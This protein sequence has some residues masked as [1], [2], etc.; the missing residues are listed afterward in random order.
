MGVTSARRGGKSPAFHLRGKHIWLATLA[1][2]GFAMCFCLLSLALSQIQTLATLM[3][4]EF[5][6]AAGAFSFP[7][8]LLIPPIAFVA[9]RFAYVNRIRTLVAGAVVGA[10]AGPV[11]LVLEYVLDGVVSGDSITFALFLSVLGAIF[12]V[13]YAG[14]FWA[15][16]RRLAPDAFADPQ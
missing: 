8:I 4:A 5:L 13:G 2:A 7:A 10:L 16:I 11:Y 1:V 14:V 6:F 15:C 9:R 3:L 12:G